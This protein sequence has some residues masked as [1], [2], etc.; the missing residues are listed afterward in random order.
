LD[1]HTIS[2]CD[3]GFLDAIGFDGQHPQRYKDLADGTYVLA[4][5]LLFHWTVIRGVVG[6]RAAYFDRWCFANQGL[7]QAAVDAFPPNPPDG[8]EPAGWHRHPP[9]GRRR[10][11]GD[12][13][14]ETID[15]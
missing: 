7:A 2:T 13:G 5:P 9:T 4:K 8:F 14:R 15:P 12:P 3:Q 1:T 10:T 11:D 6:D